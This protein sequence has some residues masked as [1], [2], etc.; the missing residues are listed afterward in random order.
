MGRRL[1]HANKRQ[2]L[3][4]AGFLSSERVQIQALNLLGISQPSSS[5][6]AAVVGWRQ[7]NGNRSNQE[8]KFDFLTTRQFLVKIDDRQQKIK[9]VRTNRLYCARVVPAEG[10]N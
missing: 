6:S 5:F 4:K 3:L 1:R 10:E 8:S 2:L 7:D 9:I